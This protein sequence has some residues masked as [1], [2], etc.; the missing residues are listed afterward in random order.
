MSAGLQQTVMAEAFH[1]FPHCFLVCAGMVTTDRSE[2]GSKFLPTQS[3]IIIFPYQSVLQG[4]S[5]NIP[6]L[7]SYNYLS[8]KQTSL[9]SVSL[10]F[11][12]HGRM[13]CH[14]LKTL[15]INLVVGTLL[16]NNV[17]INQS[18]YVG[19][20]KLSWYTCRIIFVVIINF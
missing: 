7:I 6:D 16:L 10:Q 18:F 4:L 1:V 9:C 15:Y 2:L 12:S 3:L 13:S 20:L 14:C 8:A 11:R 17:R 19:R 5:K